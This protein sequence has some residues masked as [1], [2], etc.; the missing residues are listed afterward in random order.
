MAWAKSVGSELPNRRE[1]MLSFI[2]AREEFEPEWHWTFE[3][4]ARYDDY[5]WAQDF[6]GGYKG[7]LRK[8]SKYR[9]RAVRRIYLEEV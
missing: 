3:Q 8:S 5:A 1:A 9:A 2:N 7:N 6:D 4:D